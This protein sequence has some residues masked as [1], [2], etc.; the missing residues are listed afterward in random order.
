MYSHTLGGI[1]IN[2]ID[3]VLL[4]SVLDPIQKRGALDIASRVRQRCS[5]VFRYGM[6]IGACSAD[7][8][9]PLK[10]VMELPAK[11]HFAALL[12]SEMPEFLTKVRA[13]NCSVQTRLAIRLL[14][15]TFVRTVELIGARWDQ[16]D[17]EEAIWNIPAEKMKETRAHYVPLSNH[18]LWQ[19]LNMPG[20]VGSPLNPIAIK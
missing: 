7:P 20:A 3:R 10:I 1:P 12:V 14:M 11:K 15:L 16:F 13:Y 4:K 2:Q 8:A 19:P 17:T 5:S 6:V 18:R 9:E